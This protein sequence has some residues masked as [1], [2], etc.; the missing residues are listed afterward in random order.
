MY[1]IIEANI[2]DFGFSDERNRPILHDEIV[3]IRYEIE[4]KE[5]IGIVEE[6]FWTT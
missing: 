2:Y 6:T 1:K 4:G 5:N 3:Y